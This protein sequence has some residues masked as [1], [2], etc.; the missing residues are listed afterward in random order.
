MR[1]KRVGVKG[2][3]RKQWQGEVVAA[4]EAVSVESANEVVSEPVIYG[5]L[6][7][8]RVSVGIRRA[9]GGR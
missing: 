6:L 8:W 5:E 4:V 9:V 1:P 2:V 3:E 7:R